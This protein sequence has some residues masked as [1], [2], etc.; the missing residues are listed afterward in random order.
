MYCANLVA[1]VCR[2]S[3]VFAR[4]YT[5]MF[6]LR[7]VTY[8]AFVTGRGRGAQANDCVNVRPRKPL[9]SFTVFYAFPL[10]ACISRRTD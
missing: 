2:I 3:L 7:V 1:I 4:T 8:P 6:I 5:Y 10:Y 9:K